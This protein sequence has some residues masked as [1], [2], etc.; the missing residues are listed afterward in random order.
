M[1]VYVTMRVTADQ[2][3]F[4]QAVADHADAIDRIM[5]IAKTNGLIGHRW[6]R[7]EGAVMAV[8]EWPDAESFQA[9]MGEAEAEMPFTVAGG[10]RVDVDVVIDAGVAAL[11]MPEASAF[12]VY[13]AK[14]DIQGN[15][16]E[17]GYGFGA[18]YQTTLP[19]GDYVVVTRYEDD[20]EAETAFTVVA[21]ERVEVRAEKSAAK[22]KTK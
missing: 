2:A 16:P 12:N 14:K 1:S 10:E 11:S 20:T 22:A 19:A 13:A 5:G 6:F 8:D 9:F 18:E 3:A 7:G 17:M 15:R 4:E 21:G